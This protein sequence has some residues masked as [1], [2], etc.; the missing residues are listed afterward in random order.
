MKYSSGPKGKVGEFTVGY[1]PRQPHLYQGFHFLP[2]RISFR[3]PT[4]AAPQRPDHYAA[5]FQVATKPGTDTVFCRELGKGR[6]RTW[7]CC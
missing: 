2:F 4:S 5:S 6:I 1:E 7:D 3:F